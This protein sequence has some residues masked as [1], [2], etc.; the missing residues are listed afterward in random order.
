MN[1]YYS[2]CGKP[3]TASNMLSPVEPISVPLLLRNISSHTLDAVHVG[4][5]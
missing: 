2:N 4:Y 1:E 5:F 3:A